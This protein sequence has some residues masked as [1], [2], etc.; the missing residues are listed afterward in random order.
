MDT[1]RLD[2]ESEYSVNTNRSE[3]SRHRRHRNRDHSKRHRGRGSG[4]DLDDSAAEKTVTIRTPPMDG[5]HVSRADEETIV[6]MPEDDNWGETNTFISGTT[7]VTQL[8]NE[9]LA[10]LKKDLQSSVGFHDCGFVAT[11]LFAFISYVTPIAFV[12]IPKIL[13]KSFQND[14]C[15]TVCKGSLIDMA[16]NLFILLILSWA[17]FF[18]QQ[19]TSM[20]RVFM[21]RALIMVLVILVTLT[22]WLYYV[23]WILEENEQDYT[24]IVAYA[25]RL[26]NSLLWL[27]YLSL[28]LLELRHLQNTFVLE[29]I[30]TTDGERKFYSI[31]DLSIQRCSVWVLEKYYCDFPV[32]NPALM[33]I[34]SRSSRMKQITS[35]SFKVY[36]VDGQPGNDSHGMTHQAI[37]AAVA[38]RRDA[39]HNERYYEEAEYERRIRK[40]KAR[41]V[42]ATEDAFTHIRR[43]SEQEITKA[44]GSESV[45]DPEGASKAI[46]PALARSLQKYLRTT[47]QHQHY[48]IDGILKHLAF[49]VK[50]DMTPKAFLEKYLHPGPSLTYD[51]RQDSSQWELVSDEPLVNMLKEGSVFR[52]NQQNYSLV[53]TARRLPRVRL[54]EVFVD[55]ST[56]RFVLQMQSETSV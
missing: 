13:G 17:I 11:I 33:R 5:R 21:F 52:L 32:Y 20:P 30:R 23:V 4:I 18:R 16:F 34:P 50:N 25:G 14:S 10:K 55:S 51:P 37:I 8:S 36:N 44:K 9:S 46:F 22:Y 47:R 28:A 6:N 15:G 43:A 38:R 41:L 48:D 56:H 12:V 19:R 53:V 31:G 29:V 40:R 7:D 26:T 27:H 42:A 35:N 45:M 1:D 3:R 54:Q 2:N 39:G 49:C 24:S